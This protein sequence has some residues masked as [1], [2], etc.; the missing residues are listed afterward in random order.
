MNIDIMTAL[1]EYQA[2]GYYLLIAFLVTILY[3]Y[4]FHLYKSEK[5]GRKNYERYGKIALEDDISDEPVESMSIKQSKIEQQRG[6][7]K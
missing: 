5:S 7:T 4:I 2:Y 6:A 3:W 1:V